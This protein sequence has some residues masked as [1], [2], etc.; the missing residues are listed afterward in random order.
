MKWCALL[1]EVKK[2]KSDE[3]RRRAF[4]EK[5]QVYVVA[6]IWIG[7]F[8]G[9]MVYDCRHPKHVKRELPKS[10]HREWSGKFY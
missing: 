3:Y 5:L 9:L 1:S 10:F 4:F 7:F 8:V 6:V 2:I